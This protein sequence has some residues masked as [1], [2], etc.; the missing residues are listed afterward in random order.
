M[1][2][3]GDV[4]AEPA[5]RRDVRADFP[6]LGRS[7]D[8]HAI[9]YLDSAATS[10]KPR[11][12]I[13]AVTSYFTRGGANI[14]RGKH[15][16]SEEVS[17]RYETGRLRVAQLLGCFGNEV[18]FTR[19]TTEAIN[20]VAAGLGLSTD[21]VVIT[22][23]ESHHSQQLPWRR[24]A[25]TLMVRCDKDGNAELGHFEELLRLHP[26]VVALTHCSNV[27]GVFAPVQQMASLARAAGAIV[28]VDAAQSV[29]HRRVNV[30]ELGAD[31]LA[32]SSH[33]M[34]G[35]SG[36]GV[37]YGR[38]EMLEKLRPLS[39][40]GGTVDWVD[41]EGYR[42]RKVPHRLESGTPSIEGVYGL[43]A[44]I[45]Y[46]EDLG[47]DAVSAHDSYLAARMVALAADRPYLKVLGSTT[48]ADRA[49][50]L[51]LE[52]PG[53]DNLSEIARSLS[54]SYGIMCRSG[55]LCAQA[56]VDSMSSGEVLRASAYLYNTAGEIDRLFLALDEL[57]RLAGVAQ[58][59]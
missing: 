45:E 22:T 3:L 47:F 35:P 56:L 29:A 31:F 6:I 36:L 14:H 13:E 12:V 7:I 42:L 43:L 53:L 27:T 54:D 11:S 8:G 40:G 1:K 37:L 26:K 5:F 48:G 33:K 10:L 58:T 17:D 2:N 9:T 23:L 34:L 25:K 41:L 51:S 50:V 59:L 16:L 44:A 20:L 15:Y 57:C 32:F 19:N 55:H 4:G 18:V 21:D 30:E 28:V 39:I 38:R 46:L 24:L 49:A 52:I